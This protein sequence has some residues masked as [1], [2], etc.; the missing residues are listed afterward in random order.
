M[1]KLIDCFGNDVWVECRSIS[2]A[3]L[4]SFD[5]LS[6]KVLELPNICDRLE[7]CSPNVLS[8]RNVLGFEFDLRLL[9]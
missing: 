9:L 3:G 2:C 5:R 1:Q 4:K 7:A 6:L 8:S